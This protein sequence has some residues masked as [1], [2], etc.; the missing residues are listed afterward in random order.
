[1]KSIRIQNL[2]SLE[3]TTTIELKPITVLVGENSSGKSTFLRSLPLLRQSFEVKTTGPLLWYGKYVDF[4]S[5]NEAVSAFSSEKSIYFEF[6]FGKT[7]SSPMNFS[8]PYISM[9]RSNLILKIRIVPDAK[10]EAIID[11][12]ELKLEDNLVV[13]EFN[14]EGLVTYFHVNQ[15][16]FLDHFPGLKAIQSS[17]LVPHIVLTQPFEND[18]RAF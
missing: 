14:N 9:L 13:M 7:R 1:M 2:R 15:L 6:D 4:G 3:D 10:R 5:F 18:P 16:N 11:R 17:G 8:F 12:L